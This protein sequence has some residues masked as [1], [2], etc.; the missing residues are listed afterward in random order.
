MDVS[1]ERTFK[2]SAV[3]LCRPR[4]TVLDEPEHASLTTRKMFFVYFMICLFFYS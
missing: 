3:N 4:L 1:P 2:P